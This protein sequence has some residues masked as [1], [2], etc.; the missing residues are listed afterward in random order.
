[1]HTYERTTLGSIAREWLAALACYSLLI[2]PFGCQ[3]VG[4]G[5]DLG[6][7][8]GVG[9]DAGLFIHDDFSDPLLVAGRNDD[10]DAFFVY[11]TRN[12][13]GGLEEVEAIVVEQ[14][15]GERSFI[16]FESG[17]PVHVEGPNGSFVHITYTEVSAERLVARVEFFNAVDEVTQTFPVEIDLRAVLQAIVSQVERVTGR[18]LPI[19]QVEED[20]TGGGKIRHAEQVRV[21]VFS[22]L[23]A[24]FVVPV[25]AIVALTQL[26]LGQVLLAIVDGLTLAVRNVL[27]HAL[28]PLFIVAALLNVSITR[29][30]LVGIGTIFESVPP[31]PD[32]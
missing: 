14:A 10:G 30:Q 3:L 26:I 7:V 18:E 9:P 16:A 15:G 5:P 25:V 27:F 24:I 32:V 11:G 21:T 19:T 31:P 2:A 17:R 23:F 6:D 13:D 28:A 1:M 4:G 8:P 20:I 22:P 29:V 12:S